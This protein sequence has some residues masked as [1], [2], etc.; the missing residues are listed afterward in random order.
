M[1]LTAYAA[2][3]KNLKNACQ[4]WFVECVSTIKHI[5]SVIHYTICGVVCFQLTL[6]SVMIER[7]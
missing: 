5:I 3:T 4:I 2:C 7:I 6:S 1:H